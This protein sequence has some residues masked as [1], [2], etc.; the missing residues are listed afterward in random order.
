MHIAIWEMIT[1]NFKIEVIYFVV[2][3]SRKFATIIRD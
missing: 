2:N 3:T 1:E